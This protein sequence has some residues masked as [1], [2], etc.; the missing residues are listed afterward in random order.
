MSLSS[1]LSIALTGL[2]ATTSG[3]SVVSSNLAN[4]NTAGYTNKSTSYT[5]VVLGDGEAGVAVGSYTR[6]TDVAL[7]ASYNSSTS[8]AGYYSTQYNYLQ[9]VQ[10]ILDSTSSTPSLTADLTTF[11]SDWNSLAASPESTTLQQS[12]INDG[13]KLANEIQSISS[14]VTTLKNQVTSDV[15]TGLASLNS[16]LGQIQAINGQIAS[17]KSSGQDSTNLEDNR[18]SLINKISS[19]TSVTVMQRSNGQIALYTP[20]GVA[21]LDGT[22]QTFSFD[23]TN[24]TSSSGQTV[25]SAL[26]GGSLQAQLNFID[27]S[28]SASSS[29]D[30]GT[31]VIAKI[32]DQLATFVTAL[33]GSSSS[34]VTSYSS[35]VTSSTASGAT[36]NGASVA[37]SFFTVSTN[38]STGKADPGSLTVNSAL[39]S[40][41]SV[42]PQTGL[43]AVY[44]SFTSTASYTASGLTASNVTY[45]EL[46]SSI[47]SNFQTA[48]NSVK[49]S[50]TDA[51]TQQSY[52]QTALSNAT[53]VNSD[54]ELVTLTTL[55][56]S[57]AASAKVISVIK[58]LYT[59]L[60][61]II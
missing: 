15:N 24:V 13:N 19:M 23:G 29:S 32:Q 42:L 31:G 43:S 17:A 55:Q 44:N 56:N 28:A 14:Q 30:Y 26:T 11:Q 6:A 16:Y 18:D 40:G 58:E 4:A 5:S 48:A 1:A 59:A 2:K 20:S 10:A 3:L 53:G 35:A 9:K 46:A 52:Y 36:Q 25:N 51:T 61:N 12:V 47:L 21:L 57:Y 8:N 34:F 27:T 7:T 37:S 38:A 49:A 39:L 41:S 33:T 45:S 54:S 22:A 60:E 50:S